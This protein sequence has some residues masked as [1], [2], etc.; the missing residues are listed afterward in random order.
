[1]A[2]RLHKNFLQNK[3]VLVIYLLPPIAITRRY[4]PLLLPTDPRCSL[5]MMTMDDGDG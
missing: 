4:C 2:I 5:L 1:M 3:G